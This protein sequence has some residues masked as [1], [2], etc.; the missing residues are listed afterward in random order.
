[1]NWYKISQTN[2]YDNNLSSEE[3]ESILEEIPVSSLDEENS[4]IK[5]T[6][7]SKIK[8]KTFYELTQEELDNI[9]NLFEKSYLEATGNSWTKE[10]FMS[11]AR[12]WT[13]YIGPKG[14]G[15]IAIRNQK[16]GLSKLNGVAGNPKDIYQAYSYLVKESQDNPLWGMVSKELKNLANKSG[17]ISPPGLLVKLAFKF[18]PSYV[19]GDAKILSIG[20]DGGVE[21]EYNDVGIAKKYLVANK[22]YYKFI[23]KNLMERGESIPGFIFNWFKSL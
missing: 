18:I 23:L 11:R 15:Y 21:F 3:N 2:Q 5:N 4:S 16:S 10:K 8:V 13:F 6:P 17:L 7:D 9:Y 22:A 14:T 20:L 1:M 19:Y 12:D